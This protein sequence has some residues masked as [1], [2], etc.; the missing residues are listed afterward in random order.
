MMPVFVLLIY[1][2]L[3]DLRV[4]AMRPKGYKRLTVTDHLTF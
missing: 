3:D 1:K 2:N 4:V